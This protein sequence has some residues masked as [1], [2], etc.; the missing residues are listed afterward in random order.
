MKKFYITKPI[1]YINDVPHIGHAYTTIMADVIKRYKKLMGYD[2]FFLTGTD[3]HGQ[4]IEESAIK[5]NMT[6]QELA[7]KIV[8]RF[9][10]LWEMLNVDYDKFIRTTDP[11]HVE[12]VKKIFKKVRKAG[13]IYPGEY[14]GHYC[15]SDESFV[16]EIAEDNGDG[17]KIC[18]DCG[19]ITRKVTE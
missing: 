5:Q 19:K 14:E 7:D 8:V 2:V 10:E 12:G 18:P 6:P 11:Y 3:E 17:N 13:D 16:S 9:K 1:Y 4:K 15:V